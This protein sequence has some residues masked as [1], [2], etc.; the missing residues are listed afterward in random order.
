MNLILYSN[1]KDYWIGYGFLYKKIGNYY[2]ILNE[3]FPEAYEEHDENE[4]LGMAIKT[5]YIKPI[6]FKE[7]N[8][9]LKI[10]K[11]LKKKELSIFII[12][13]IENIE[14]P[15]KYLELNISRIDYKFTNLCFNKI[16]ND[17]NLILK[18]A[19]ELETQKNLIKNSKEYFNF[20]KMII[21][22]NDCILNNSHQFFL[23][24]KIMVGDFFYL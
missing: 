19:H 13:E 12:G 14:I 10:Q 2:Y 21:D 6:D 17:D 20:L 9:N 1:K 24:K 22:K 5:K 11:D 8:I 16:F 4:L 23:N 15:Q 7:I 3:D 18:I